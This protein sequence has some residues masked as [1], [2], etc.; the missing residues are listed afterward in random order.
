M[1]PGLYAVCPDYRIID[2]VFL[3]AEMPVILELFGEAERDCFDVREIYREIA[4]QV[5]LEE[6]LG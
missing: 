6:F 2:T 4:R 1:E 3:N 5:H